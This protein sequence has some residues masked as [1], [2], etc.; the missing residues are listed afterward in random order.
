M[1]NTGT[2]HILQTIQYEKK[3]K[4]LLGFR[5]FRGVDL[6]NYHVWSKWSFGMHQKLREFQKKVY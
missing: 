3:I 2:D 5:Q 1:K 6:W 4:D